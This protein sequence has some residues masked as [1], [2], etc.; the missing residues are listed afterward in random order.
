MVSFLNAI[1]ANKSTKNQKKEAND[2][3]KKTR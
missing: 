1:N 2:R 3:I